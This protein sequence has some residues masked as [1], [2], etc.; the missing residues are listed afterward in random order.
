MLNRV[1]RTAER[2]EV[3]ANPTKDWF[4]NYEWIQQP[5]KEKRD[6]GSDLQWPND[7]NEHF[8][9]ENIHIAYKYIKMFTIISQQRNVHLN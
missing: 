4:P 6:Q 9:K 7:M 2:E 8:W 5:K 1:R 3:F